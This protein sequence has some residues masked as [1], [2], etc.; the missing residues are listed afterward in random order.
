MSAQAL[1]APWFDRWGLVADGEP[2]VTRFG[3][4]LAPVR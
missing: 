4:R 2:F 1:L 3:S